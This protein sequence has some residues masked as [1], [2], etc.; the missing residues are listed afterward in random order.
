M[1]SEDTRA[2]RSK[3]GC[4]PFVVRNELCERMLDGATGTALRRWI[5][6]HPAFRKVKAAPIS[7]QNLTTW[8]ST[9]YAA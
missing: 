4:L 3:I 6:A 7:A 2:Y 9:G 8:R 5:N 1:T